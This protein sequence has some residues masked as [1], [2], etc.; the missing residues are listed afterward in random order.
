M[1]CDYGSETHERVQALFFQCL[2]TLYQGMSPDSIARLDS[3]R[4]VRQQTPDALPNLAC[5]RLT[6]LYYP[7]LRIDMDAPAK[8]FVEGQ[9]WT[10]YAGEL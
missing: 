7:C 5:K 3:P 6:L 4:Q 8:G 10:S 9:C 2:I 1:I